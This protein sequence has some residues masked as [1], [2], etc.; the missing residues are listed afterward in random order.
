[1]SVST[2]PE[3]VRVSVLGGTAQLDSGLPAH[4]PVAA[5]MP[6]LLAAL[7]LRDDDAT[8]WTLARLDGARLLPG[9]TLA[10]A[11]V[12]D[13]DLLLVRAA[14]PGSRSPLVDD[15]ADGVAAALR[16]DRPGWTS[17]ASRWVGHALLLTATVAAV[18]AGRIAAA[19]ERTA[20]LAVSST[21]AALLLLVALAGHR[22]DTDPRTRATASLGAAVL[23]A[24]A[25]SLVALDVRGAAQFALAA[26]AAGTVAVVG[27]RVWRRA[28]AVHVAVA[29]V[30]A[31]S[32]IAGTLAAVWSRPTDDVAAVTAVLAVGVVLLAPR[33]SIALGR[34][35]LPAVPTIAP[36]PGSDAEPTAVEGVDALALADRD[37]LGAIADLALGDMRA[38]ADRAAVTASIL[39]GVLAGAVLVAGTATTVLATA[40]ADSTVALIFGTCIIVGLAARGRTHA[41]RLQSAILVAGAGL[42]AIAATLAL[43][44]GT[45]GPS[46]FTV[47]SALLGIGVGAL[48]LGTVV[49]EGDYSPPAVR[50]AEITEYAVL[51]SLLPLLLWMLDVYRA[52]RQL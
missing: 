5:L 45:G 1:M 34:L 7:R 51:V 9:E 43:L 28:L 2:E 20:V 6:D 37:P 14:L 10:Q 29:T 38:V 35:P 52:V 16:R 44:V 19:T 47:F 23:A 13:G 46:A 41:D 11:G 48:L 25:A 12:L 40:A 21:G 3:L 22:L 49:A 30:A 26:I 31:L 39:S 33:L 27:T 17:E 42:S 50:A 18:P 15:V 4:L 36:D 32:A 8:V 24:V